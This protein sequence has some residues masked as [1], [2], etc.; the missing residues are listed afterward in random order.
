MKNLFYYI[1]QLVSLKKEKKYVNKKMLLKYFT[2]KEFT[3][4]VP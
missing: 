4:N 2:P 1:I 3:N